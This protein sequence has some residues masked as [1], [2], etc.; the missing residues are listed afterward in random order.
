MHTYFVTGTDTG[1]G[2]TLVIAA[3]LAAAGARALK[4]AGVK[5]LAAGGDRVGAAWHNADAVTLAGLSRPPLA[6]ADVNAVTLARPMAPHLA[7]AGERIELSA[8]TLVAHVRRAA[9]TNPDLLLVEGVGG[10]LVPLNDRETMADVATAFGA[11]VILVVGMRLGCLN[12]AL[13]SAAAIRTA[14]LPLAGWIA[15]S[16]WPPM[17][18]LQENMTALACR[19]QAPCIARIPFLDRAAT[20]ARI[21]PYFDLAPVLS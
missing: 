21:V 11:P 2:K 20:P 12:H 8:A 15:N 19:L 14:G 6:Y 9:G 1:V 10:W 7:A 5:P 3:L 18:A 17:A 4:V 16:P 13:L